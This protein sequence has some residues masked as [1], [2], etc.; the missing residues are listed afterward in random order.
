[1]NTTNAKSIV[2]DAV[3]TA[4]QYCGTQVALA[5]KAQ[6]TQGAVGKYL[7]GD[8]LPTGV[9]AKK[10]S[11]AVDYTLDKSCFAPHIFDPPSSKQAAA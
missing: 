4:V 1:M 3:K 5:E 11:A 8:A 6:I 9:T 10:L 2:K 7:R